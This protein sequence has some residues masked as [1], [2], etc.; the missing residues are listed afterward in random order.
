MNVAWARQSKQRKAITC[1]IRAAVLDEGAATLHQV[2]I[3]VSDAYPKVPLPELRD[4][5]V[6][7]VSGMSRRR[8][9]A[10]ERMSF[11]LPLKGDERNA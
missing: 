6:M 7:V 8:E 10:I 3:R 11:S 2:V 1:A 9:I 4:L 5:A